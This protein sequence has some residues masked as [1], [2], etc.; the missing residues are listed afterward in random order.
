MLRQ[1]LTCSCTLIVMAVALPSAV[2][3]Q[4]PGGLLDWIHK[5]SGPQFIGPALSYATGGEAARFRIS[6]AYRWSFASDDVMDP[7]GS[8][9]MFSLQ[10]TGEFK[11]FQAWSAPIEAGLGL[12]L[13]RFGGDV[14]GFWHFSIPIYAQALVPLSDRLDLRVGLQTHYFFE[15]GDDDF[16]P[17][18]VDVRRNRGEFVNPTP[19][20]G[21]DWRFGR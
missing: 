6:G 4:R 12:G 5:L 8:I 9:T 18:A 16:S 17:I 21:I 19:M 2:H 14:D 3:A 11:L 13:H 15:F 20:I 7:D 10:P 1:V